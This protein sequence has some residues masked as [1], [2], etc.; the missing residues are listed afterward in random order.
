MSV[1]KKATE[2]VTVSTAISKMSLIRGLR[3]N[4]FVG[5]RLST[6]NLYGMFFNIQKT[7]ES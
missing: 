7:R 2:C 1:D 3:V 5:V 4:C 6:L